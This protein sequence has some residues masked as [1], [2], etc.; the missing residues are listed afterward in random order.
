MYFINNFLI[1]AAMLAG[2]SNNPETNLEKAI[3]ETQ[4]VFETISH[5]DN[6]IPDQEIQAVKDKIAEALEKVIRSGHNLDMQSLANAI[7]SGMSE[8]FLGSV[9]LKAFNPIIFENG[10]SKINVFF[11]KAI[12]Q[13]NNW[14]C[15]FWSLA[16]AKVIADLMA[17]NKPIDGREIYNRVIKVIKECP[18][19][20][21][22]DDYLLDGFEIKERINALGLQDSTHILQN[23]NMYGGIAPD[24][25][26]VTSKDFQNEQIYDC[27]CTSKSDRSLKYFGDHLAVR[28]AYFNEH[29]SCVNSLGIGESKFVNFICNIGR[30]H[31]ILISVIKRA[32]RMPVIVILDSLANDF[33]I[34]EPEKQ[35]V[36]QIDYI[37][38]INRYLQR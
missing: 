11:I 20:N 24:P 10:N 28:D 15:G 37:K 19:L 29:V 13:G 26:V 30:A 32:N 1:A 5:V 31:W 38:T 3:I 4:T 7:L 23:D 2:I 9:N 17:E 36:L 16:H 35:G 34:N 25:D 12:E 8:L 6:N 14:A 33:K 21:I 27:I 18:G 22:K